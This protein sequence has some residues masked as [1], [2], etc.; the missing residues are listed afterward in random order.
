M[1][2]CKQNTRHLLGV[3]ALE[4]VAFVRQEYKYRAPGRSVEIVRFVALRSA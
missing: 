2:V 4:T 3:P 1:F